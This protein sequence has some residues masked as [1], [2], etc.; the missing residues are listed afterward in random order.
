[1]KPATTPYSKAWQKFKNTKGYT[2]TAAS[3]VMRGFSQP[4]IDNMLRESFDAG[5]NAKQD[6]PT[7]DKV[8]EHAIKYMSDVKG[9]KNDLFSMF[10][11][12]FIE[13]IQF[14]QTP[15]K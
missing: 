15:K 13:V 5:W 12:K 2:G 14:A 10:R 1:M 8:I 9:D 3:M 11:E 7:I 6:L 4:Y